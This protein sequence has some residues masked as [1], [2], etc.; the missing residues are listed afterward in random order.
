[1]IK[2]IPKILIV[3]RLLISLIFI[4]IKPSSDLPTV[5]IVLLLLYTG[6]LSDVFDG[7]LAR[8]YNIATTRL[9]VYD[10]VV[11]LIFY[12]SAFFYLYRLEE[13]IVTDNAYLIVTILSLEVCMYVLSLVR[14]RKL[15]S[16]HAL[17]SKIWGMYLVVE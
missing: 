4:G 3:Y 9:R 11:D 13:N 15:P 1:M 2:E 8:S 16:P 10:T 6:I 7:I 14:F 5:T 17:L 12:L